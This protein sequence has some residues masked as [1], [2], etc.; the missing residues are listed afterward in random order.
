[1]SDTN[2]E[3]INAAEI[4]TPKKKV[5]KGKK[6]EVSDNE[7]VIKVNPWGFAFM[8]LTIAIIAYLAVGLIAY[9][10]PFEYNQIDEEYVINDTLLV[11]LLILILIFLGLGIYFIWIRKTPGKEELEEEPTGEPIQSDT[12]LTVVYIENDIDASPQEVKSED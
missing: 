1:M 6:Q 4:D 9:L 3:I 10:P 11:I 8:T 12:E 7:L 5:R 2:L